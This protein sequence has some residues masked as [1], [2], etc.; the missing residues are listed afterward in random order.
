M[1]NLLDSVREYAA[2]ELIGNL[3]RQLGESEGGISKAVSGL[4]P[5]LL[6]GLIGKTGEPASAEH[7]FQV[8][9]N[10]GHTSG[11]VFDPSRPPS[12][13]DFPVVLF[14]AGLPAIIH[15]VA[16]FSG[17]RPSSVSFLLDMLSPAVTGMLHDKIKAG[18][19]DAAGFRT[20]LLGEQN[21]IFSALP[22]GLSSILG[23]PVQGHPDK[24]IPAAGGNSWLWP[25]LLLL[26]LGGGLLLYLKGC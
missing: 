20:W 22:T 3:A 7:I 19:L 8:V 18:H 9:G 17:T 5:V 25:F 23:L 10:S 16:A 24:N 6:A 21:I 13:Q 4:A 11:I 1:S 26:G 14:G 2:P 12:K 15:A